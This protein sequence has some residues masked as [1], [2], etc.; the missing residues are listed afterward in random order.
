MDYARCSSD[1]DLVTMVSWI[2][3]AP[4]IMINFIDSP[5]KPGRM[6][7]YN[8]ESLQMWVKQPE[9]TFARWIK[10]REGYE[11]E[12]MG[13]GGMPDM[14][15]KYVK[16]YT[17]EFVV[18][19]EIIEKIQQGLKYPVILDAE[20]IGTERIGNLRG[21]FGIGDLHGQLPGYRVYKLKTDKPLISIPT[22][23]D[24]DSIRK[25]NDKFIKQM[26]EEEKRSINKAARTALNDFL[27]Y[28]VFE[29]ITLASEKRK[30]Q[31]AKMLSQSHIMSAYQELRSPFLLDRSNL[32]ILLE[33]LDKYDKAD[34]VFV[35]PLNIE[36]YGGLVREIDKQ[37]RVATVVELFVTTYADLFNRQVITQVIE[38]T[39]HSSIT[40]EDVKS[41]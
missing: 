21:E 36:L 30:E 23:P 40:V 18:K 22:G 35:F 12:P 34:D 17:G 1:S 15:T 37:A 31:R 41:I 11:M 33:T 8:G 25:A 14:T 16:M 20:Y 32:S 19:D 10:R 27:L 6:G 26:V 7:C 9:N 4:S 29:L 38:R 13:H 39:K 24:V 28:A 5:D 2:E 3:E